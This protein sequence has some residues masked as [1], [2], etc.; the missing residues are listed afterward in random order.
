MS[1]EWG[2]VCVCVCVCV[3]SSSSL[4][5]KLAGL[6]IAMYVCACTLNKSMSQN[7]VCS[8]SF[9]SY[10]EKWWT[11]TLTFP[12]PSYR[13]SPFH[14]SCWGWK[15]LGS[16]NTQHTTHPL[17]ASCFTLSA[18]I[19]HHNCYWFFIKKRPLWLCDVILSP[20]CIQCVMPLTVRI[21]ISLW[22]SMVTLLSPL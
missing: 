15:D 19:L 11:L 17:T 10:G 14:P 5:P 16:T 22:Y 12:L 6:H 21:W 7:P 9:S 1:W 8:P 2:F 18:R 3:I 4:D 20:L 13:L